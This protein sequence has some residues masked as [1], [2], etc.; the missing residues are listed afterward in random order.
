MEK[1]MHEL[2]RRKYIPLEFA[3]Y[4]KNDPF[5]ERLRRE[6][7]AIGA[8]KLFVPIEYL[9]GTQTADGYCSNKSK[10]A[11]KAIAL[12]G[13]D[14]LLQY[15]VIATAVFTN[16]NADI[17]VED[18]HHRGIKAN[19]HGIHKIPT[20]V[21]TINQMSEIRKRMNRKPDSPNDIAL[22]LMMESCDAIQSF[23]MKGINITPGETIPNA[24][25]I[26]DLKRRFTS[27]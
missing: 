25:N 5:G 10:R 9:H 3:P 18:G 1:Y 2:E 7:F 15:P 26:E 24:K 13:I 16:G 17:Y 6:A 4:E 14:F 12:G 21:L 19:K 23:H 8:E 11:E 27:F 20:L 22:E